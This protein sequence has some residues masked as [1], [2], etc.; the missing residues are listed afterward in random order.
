MEK[1]G[2]EAARRRLPTLLEQAHQGRASVIMKHGKPYAVLA[3][4]DQCRMSA[5]RVGLL[6]LRGSGRG[7]WGDTPSA[8]VAA[9]RDE[10]Q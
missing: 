6:E 9:M 7:L 5:T 1:I 3:S 10:W 4:L 8:A 2:S